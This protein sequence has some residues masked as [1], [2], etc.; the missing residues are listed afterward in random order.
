MLFY[1]IINDYSLLAWP[2]PKD[3]QF[4]VKV[5]VVVIFRLCFSVWFCGKKKEQI[6]HGRTQTDTDPKMPLHK[7]KAYR[8]K[9]VQTNNES[10]NV[11]GVPK[12]LPNQVHRFS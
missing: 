12:V 11:K 6:R 1:N 3:K 2:D 8:A 4:F 5:H 7:Q 10:V 9:K